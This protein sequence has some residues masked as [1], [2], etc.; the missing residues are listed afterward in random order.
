MPLNSGVAPAFAA[1]V[2]LN[3]GDVRPVPLYHWGTTDHA[4]QCSYIYKEGIPESVVHLGSSLLGEVRPQ[5]VLRQY[6]EGYRMGVTSAGLLQPAGNAIESSYLTL[7]C[8]YAA[9]G[10]IA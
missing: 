1:L 2:G 4:L 3:A 6:G 10:R 7:P 9:F 8:Y 5:R